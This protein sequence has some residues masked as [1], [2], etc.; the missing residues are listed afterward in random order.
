MWMNHSFMGGFMWIF[1]IVLL[2]GLA[3]FIKWAIQSS[4]SGIKSELNSL[5]MLKKRYA[6]GE[7][8]KAEYKQ[9]RKDL[10]S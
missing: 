10:L 2:V 9:K 3:F 5:E 7:I 4:K 1:W 8:D 6:H